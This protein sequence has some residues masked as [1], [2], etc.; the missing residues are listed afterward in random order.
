MVQLR[1]VESLEQMTEI[2]LKF[3]RIIWE[4]ADNKVM[5]EMLFRCV[6]IPT[7]VSTYQNYDEEK[8]I[9]SFDEHDQMI[10]YFEKGDSCSGKKAASVMACHLE[11]AANLFNTLA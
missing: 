4:S 7:M 6:N 10:K 11:S 3:H 8:M 2:N 9:K 1:S 5:N